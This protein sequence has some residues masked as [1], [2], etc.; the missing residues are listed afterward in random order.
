MQGIPTVDDVRAWLNV[1]TNAVP[2][3]DLSEI[4]VGELAIQTR[5]LRV[6]TDPD[7]GPVVATLDDMTA[8][9]AVD[10]GIP[11]AAYMIVWGDAA[12]DNVTVA[13]DGTASV[14]HTY[15]GP[16][17]YMSVL[18][19][20]AMHALAYYSYTVPGGSGDTVAPEA[21]YPEALARALLRRCQRNV[22][23]RSV[24]L[25]A[26][27]LEGSEFGPVTLPAWD[28]EISRLEASYLIPVI[29]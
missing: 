6:P 3:A 20:D 15:A 8:T 5:L 28:A 26:F 12:T 13:D 18:Y 14:S 4:L 21:M 17:T 23:A 2:D 27:G 9:L 16:G 24:P 25:G 19:D 22:A 1:S 7:P 11:G 29:A 10:G